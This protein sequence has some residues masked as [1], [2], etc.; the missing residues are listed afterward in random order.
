MI[1]LTRV[2]TIMAEAASLV[3]GLDGQDLD[4][5]DAVTSQSK[6]RTR[7]ERA[8]TSQDLQLLATRFELAAALVRVEYWSARGKQDPLGRD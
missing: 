3:E 2:R 7:Q 4:E 6:S 8:Q 5:S 1:D